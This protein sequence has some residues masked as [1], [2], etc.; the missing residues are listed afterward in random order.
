[1]RASGCPGCRCLG[2]KVTC[3]RLHRCPLVP[4]DLEKKE[5][6]SMSWRP[7]LLV[8]RVPSLAGSCRTVTLCVSQAR[9]RYCPISSHASRMSRL[10]VACWTRS[11]TGT[12]DPSRGIVGIVIKCLQ[13]SACGWTCKGCGSANCKTFTRGC[14]VLL[15][16]HQ[17][18]QLACV[19][20]RVICYACSNQTTC[21]QLAFVCPTTKG[22]CDRF[23]E[24][25]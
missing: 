12:D 3:P 24:W 6:S 25:D 2:K 17:P 13:V 4:G 18:V 14:C 16:L 23:G 22:K 9:N 11:T 8:W 10:F 5:H 21:P 1:M 19:C 7:V 20:I 15:A